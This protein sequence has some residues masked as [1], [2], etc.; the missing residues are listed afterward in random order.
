MLRNKTLNGD[1][2]GRGIIG[3]LGCQQRISPP[4][5]RI[6]YVIVK[7]F[8][9]GTYLCYLAP[10]LHLVLCLELHFNIGLHQNYD[11][12]LTSLRVRPL[13]SCFFVIMSFRSFVHCEAFFPLLGIFFFTSSYIYKMCVGSVLGKSVRVH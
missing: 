10:V 2:C 6:L 4:L 5:L 9:L 1:A 7:W 8:S 11:V 3:L 12:I 13:K